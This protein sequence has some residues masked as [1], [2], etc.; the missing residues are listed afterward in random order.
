[1][2]QSIPARLGL[3]DERHIRCGCLQ[4]NEY[5]ITSPSNHG[6]WAVYHKAIAYV[7]YLVQRLVRGALT[8]RQQLLFNVLPRELTV[9]IPKIYVIILHWR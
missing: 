3:A 7:R 1:M 6:W 9:R 4:V 2:T 5:A 8:S